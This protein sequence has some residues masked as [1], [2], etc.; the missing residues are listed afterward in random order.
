MRLTRLA[1]PLRDAGCIHTPLPAHRPDI[2]RRF[3][4]NSNSFK[5]GLAT[6]VVLVI[7]RL[8]LGCHFLYE[9]L[10]KIKH[11]DEFSARPFLTQAKGPMAP[12]FYSMVP[13]L[14]GRERL[15]IVQDEK[16]NEVITGQCYLDAWNRLKDKAIDHYQLSDDQA[17]EAEAI[18]KT[19]ENGLKTYLEENF[20]DI[21]AYFGS[22]DRFEA[23]KAGENAGAEF[24]QKRL[25]E[26]QAKL[27]GE[28]AGW[29]DQ[30]DAMGA[31]YQ[32]ALWKLLDE[33]QRAKGALPLEAVGP[34]QLPVSLLLVDSRS[35]LIDK[36]VTY[37]LTAIG[38]CLLVGLFTRAAAI[39]GGLFMI[40]VLLTQP[41]LPWIY[42][43][44]PEVTGHALLVDK[45]FIE[46]VALFLV[47]T[48]AVGR[49]GGLDAFV[50]RW[51][52]APFC[53]RKK[54]E[55]EG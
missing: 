30:L 6:V 23:K 52:V 15:A 19:Y 54:K 28:V 51:I 55:S 16:G 40:S 46:M 8:S 34:E 14:Y 50:H 13:D 38:F 2:T 36:G 12:L 41:P 35:D 32:E 53:S 27:R 45:N 31:A 37:A 39:G 33:D 11:S 48:T 42:P 21:R 26:E 3:P 9:G 44:A 18:L 1:E 22:L 5:I 20:E 47:A 7:L 29:L 49:W 25:W 17:K 4:L 43:P 24:D 10:W